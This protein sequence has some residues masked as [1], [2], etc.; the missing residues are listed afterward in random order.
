MKPEIAG[1][2][3]RILISLLGRS[4]RVKRLRS[5][6]GLKGN[7]ILYTF[8][9]GVQFPLIFIY[10]KMDIKILISKSRDGS[11]V[12]SL[13]RKMGFLPV[14]G[15]SSKGGATAAKQLIESL[16]LGYPGAITPDGPKGPPEIVKRG[17]SLIPK[18]AR[19][20]VVP[21]GVRAFPCINLKSWDSYLIPLPFS[22][23]TVSEGEPI[24]PQNCNEE[25]LTSAI[26]SEASRARL[27]TCP[28]SVFQIT[29]IKIFAYLITPIISLVLFIRAKTERF[30]RS[31]I[32]RLVS[33]RPVWL[34]G[35][36]LGEINGLMP[37][38]ELLK[39]SD[40]PYF[41][42]CSTPAARAFIK[43]KNLRG[44]FLPLDVPLFVNR[45]LN[46]LNP[47][48]L[49]LAETEFWPV[50]L[51]EVVT[52]G[53]TAGLIN[54]RLS[55]KSTQNYMIIR[56]LFRDTLGY[57]RAILT[58]TEKDAERFKAL[59]L[60]TIVAGDSK[61]LIKP[62]PPEEDW[63]KMIKPGTS[64]ILV[65][66]STRTGED[67]MI[68]QIAKETQLTPVLVP[69]HPGRISEIIQ[70][71]EKYGFTPDLWTD[72]P[73]NSNCLIV[74][75]KGVL[76]SLYGLASIAF[77]GG[78][79][80]PVGGHNI[81]EPLAHKIPVIIGPEYFH[82]S[83]IVNEAV[84]NNICRVFTTIESG[85]VSVKE[86]LNTKN[87]TDMKN[88]SQGFLMELKKLLKLMEVNL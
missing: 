54:G 74:D 63:L 28:F 85:V 84:E 7:S 51:H 11:L 26:N 39:K 87:R 41:L 2:L 1:N 53:I 43:E 13:C 40:I 16:S 6:T 61:T 19:V 76:S 72:K 46:N 9:H 77:V 78:T 48:A 88:S 30:E 49:I 64:G 21:V 4:W 71:A 68:L 62:Q 45:F 52:R 34:H 8:W 47:S 23:L 5:R 81:H 86:L 10:R 69:R 57:F 32:I 66:G 82:Y 75:T 20:P 12:A 60:N 65:A 59:G 18:R 55:K 83:D 37:V 25:T 29:F 42:T 38:L 79:I 33:D 67:E 58:R 27:H 44:A 3:G 24:G 17:V 70:L 15:S 22:F 50:L 80:A 14:R 31:G 36:S 73:L 35:S 56:S